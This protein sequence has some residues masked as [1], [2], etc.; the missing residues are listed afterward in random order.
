MKAFLIL[1]MALFSCMSQA[2]TY[3]CKVSGEYEHDA[4]G[5]LV[6]TQINIYLKS[7]I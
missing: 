7:T 5:N 6:T 3:S 2:L 4:M 1:L